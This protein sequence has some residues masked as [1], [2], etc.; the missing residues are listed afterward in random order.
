MRIFFYVKKITYENIEDIRCIRA[1][2]YYT[3][4]QQF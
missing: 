4:L 1:R 3:I 2:K